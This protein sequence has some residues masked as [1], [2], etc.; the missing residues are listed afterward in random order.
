M[1]R[2]KRR[3]DRLLILAQRAREF[4]ARDTGLVAE[5][6]QEHASICESKAAAQALRRKKSKA[7]PGK[8]A[9]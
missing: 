2:L 6:F 1:Q 8:D 9:V 5:L 3:P 4:A 7:K